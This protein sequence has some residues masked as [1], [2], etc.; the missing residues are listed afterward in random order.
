[1]SVALSKAEVVVREMKP[2]DLKFASELHAQALP[3]GLFPRLGTRFLRFY[4]GTFLRSR[5]AVALIGLRDG[6]P[7]GF[8]TGSVHERAYYRW[9]IRRRGIVLGMAGLIALVR[10]PVLAAYFARTR[11]RRYAAGFLRLSRRPC[12]NTTGGTAPAVLAHIAVREDDRGAGTGAALVETFLQMLRREGVER[13]RLVTLSGEHGAGRFYERL[14]WGA[15]TSFS[16][17]DGTKWT[18]YE[19]QL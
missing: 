11:L 14:G 3:H 4:L 12:L 5:D 15:V 17:S 16:D 2:G 13:A 6:Q 19:V 7:S 1:M 8:L 9:V 18:R 10:R